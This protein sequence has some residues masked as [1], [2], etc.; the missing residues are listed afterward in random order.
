M[1]TRFKARLK[2]INIT[3]L[4]YPGFPTDLQPLWAVLM[5][6]ASGKTVI[7]EHIFKHRFS[8][9]DEIRRM[10]GEFILRDNVCEVIPSALKGADV[11]IPDLRAGAALLIA[12][13]IAKGKTLLEGKEH[14][15]RGYEKLDLKLKKLGADIKTC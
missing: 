9:L 14:L 6:R 15:D 13:L 5:T 10:G 3:T 11:K 2:P 4:P 7:Q 12:S 1:R 8:Y